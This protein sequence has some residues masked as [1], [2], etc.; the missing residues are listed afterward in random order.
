MI[1]KKR[2]P[3]AAFVIH[4]MCRWQIPRARKNCLPIF[5][6]P[7]KRLAGKAF[8]SQFINDFDRCFRQHLTLDDFI[9]FQLFEPL[10]EHFLAD[11]RYRFGH[12]FKSFRLRPSVHG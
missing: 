5:A 7:E 11:C 3:W 6:F 4:H 9:L 10:R 1:I 8:I 2:L 12:I